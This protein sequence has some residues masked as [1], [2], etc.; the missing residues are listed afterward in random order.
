MFTP[1]WPS[2][3]SAARLSRVVLLILGLVRVP[4]PQAD[5]HNVR[6]HDGPGEICPYHDHLLRWHP[7]ADQDEDV[8]LVHWHWFI[9]Q[10]EEVENQS[11]GDR[12]HPA[13]HIPALHAHQF[14]LMKADWTGA[15][16]LRE[17]SRRPLHELASSLST[18]TPIDWLSSTVPA[19]CSPSWKGAEPSVPAQLHA[20]LCALHQHWNC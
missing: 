4:L 10:Y 9:P 7:R 18:A 20:G 6:H 2:L 8:A 19:A 5:Y 14:D 15:P 16:V 1:Q 3:P 13:G 12:D 17:S 11:A